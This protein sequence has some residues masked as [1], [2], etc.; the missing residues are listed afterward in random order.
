MTS[1]LCIIQYGFV[2]GKNLKKLSGIKPEME[3]SGWRIFRTRVATDR[4][5]NSD[6]IASPKHW[7]CGT[8]FVLKAFFTCNKRI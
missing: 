3:H 1:A 5:H 7:S 2:C 6:C 8:K 4:E